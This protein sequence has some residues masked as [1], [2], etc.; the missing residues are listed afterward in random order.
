MAAAGGRRARC[1]R[2]C[3]LP[4]PRAGD[5]P[6]VALTLLADVPDLGQLT[7]QQMVD[8]SGVAPL[9]RASGTLRGARLVRGGRG[10]VRAARSRAPLVAAR[11][12]PVSKVCDPRL[13]VAG[14]PTQGALT[15]CRHTLLIILSARLWTRTR[16]REPG[17]SAAWG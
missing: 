12:N 7:R 8:V 14:T 3:G 13:V 1:A 2:A 15:A 6:V 17:V 5:W 11:S 9:Y 10:R 4:A 16:W